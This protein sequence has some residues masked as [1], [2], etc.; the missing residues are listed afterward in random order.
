MASFY[1]SAVDCTYII[2]IPLRASEVCDPALAQ[3][4]FEFSL[5][6]RFYHPDL[7]KWFFCFGV[8]PFTQGRL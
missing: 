6:L 5:V 7:M 8:G 4:H 2:S 3:R 1:L